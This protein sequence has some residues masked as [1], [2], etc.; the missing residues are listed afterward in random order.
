MGIHPSPDIAQEIMEDLLR[1]LEQVDVYI[2]D[3]G[4]FHNNW[5]SHLRTLDKVLTILQDSNFTVSPLKCEWAVQETDWLG[6]WLTPKGLKPWKKKIEAILAIQEP[7]TVK[8]LRSFIGAVNFYRDMYPKRSHLMAPLT[9]LAPGKGTVKWNAECQESFNQ[10][11][12]LLAK[13]DFLRYPDHN[14][15]FHV[16]A[17][18]SNLQLGAVII[19]DGAPV[20]YYSRKMNSAQR[21]YTVREKKLLS[22]VETLKEFCTMLYRASQLHV[23]TDHKNNTFNK[24]HTQRVLRW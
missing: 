7:R 24:F 14:K 8:Q 5:D 22:I 2:D 10:I 19:Q 4:C 11:K 23:Y 16:Y 15:P 1:D 17:D 12:A 21:N 18:A 9:K 20:A 13:D 6:Y 3:V